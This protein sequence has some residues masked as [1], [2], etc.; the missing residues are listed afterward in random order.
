LTDNIPCPPKIV[1]S[2]MNGS[3]F[4]CLSMSACQMRCHP[5]LWSVGEHSRIRLQPLC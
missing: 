3:Q 1:P 4:M 5:P 2:V